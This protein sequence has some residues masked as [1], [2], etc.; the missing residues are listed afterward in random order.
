MSWFGSFYNF[1]YSAVFP[2]RPPNAQYGYRWQAG[3]G[4]PA[5]LRTFAPSPGPG[6]YVAFM[7]VHLDGS[8]DPFAGDP[9]APGAV[10]PR[11]QSV[12]P[13]VTNLVNSVARNPPPNED[14]WTDP[15]V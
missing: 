14:G 5:T 12:L 13:A 3:Q 4:V 9:N 2:Q 8:L 1:V 10:F 7:G 11:P 6:V 15:P